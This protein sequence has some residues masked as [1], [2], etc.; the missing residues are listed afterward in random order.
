MTNQIALYLGLLILAAV[1]LDI[2]MNGGAAV[3]FLASKFL[4]LVQWVIFWN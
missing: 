2:V 4:D 1:G 3:S